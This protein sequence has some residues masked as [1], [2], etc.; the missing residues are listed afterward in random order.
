M[1]NVG[2]FVSM[3]I[4]ST[5]RLLA[6]ATQGDPRGCIEEKTAC[7]LFH[8]LVQEGAL[9]I[10]LVNEEGI[11]PPGW[12]GVDSMVMQA[13]SEFEGGEQ[14]VANPCKGKGNFKGCKGKK[15][16]LGKTGKPMF[17]LWEQV[18]GGFGGEP[19]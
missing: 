9:P 14:G 7:E 3:W 4:V 5:I 12:S 8:A 18:D 16:H 13:Y 11:P 19:P 10:Q 6:T 2:G 1:E 17:S 15:S